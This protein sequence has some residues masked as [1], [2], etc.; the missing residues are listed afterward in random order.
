MIATSVHDA[1]GMPAWRTWGFGQHA[2][3]GV[4]GLGALRQQHRL[5]DQHLAQRW[6]RHNLPPIPHHSPAHPPE[7]MRQGPQHRKLIRVRSRNASG[8]RARG[9]A[10]RANGCQKLQQSISALHKQ[11]LR[12]PYDG[13]LWRVGAARWR[14][15]HG[16]CHPGP[17][18]PTTAVA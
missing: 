13:A 2:D 4:H 9:V 1:E 18:R 7:R 12:T 5:Q 8:R 6:A 10:P 15:T 16:L 11:L 14:A 3:N 17:G